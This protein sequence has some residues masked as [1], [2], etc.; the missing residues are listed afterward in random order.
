MHRRHFLQGSAAV[1][2]LASSGGWAATRT[3]RN[4]LVMPSAPGV[5]P[6][7]AAQPVGFAATPP[8]APIRASVDRIIAVNGCT[9]PFRAQGPRIEAERIGRKTVVHNYGHGGSGWSLSWGAAEH[10]LRLVRTADADVR[11]LAVIG[12][13]AI[14]LTTALVAQRAG[15]R[16]RIYA[17]EQLP[18]VRSF[19]ATGVWSP[20]SR[21]CTSAEATAAFR[22]RWEEMARISFRRYQTLL[23]LPGEPIEWRDGYALSDVPFDQRIASPETHEP[24][25]PPLE[26]DLLGDLGP[27]SEPVAAGAH[28]FPVPFVRRYSQLTFNLSTYARLL[29]DDFLLAGG[30]LHTR[31]FDSPRQFADL[32]EKCVINATGYGARALLG[33][34]SV[35]PIR[36]QTARLIPQP[37]VTYGLVW[38]GH[39]LNVVPRRDGILVQSQ[40]PNDYNNADGAPDRAASEAAV[41]ELARLFA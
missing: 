27:H 31:S 10:A 7:P 14:G 26:R 29:M 9:R 1:L 28:P 33:D 17:R 23:G 39:N 38:R 3:S 24:D 25:Y 6:A 11:E 37:E 41:R 19:Y 32:R 30:E 40:G 4:A 21:V 34:E 35:V 22:T 5:A 8:L 36:G 18:D 13:G 15:L 16:V 12:C 2:A 20:D